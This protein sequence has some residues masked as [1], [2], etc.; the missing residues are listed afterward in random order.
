MLL[1]NLR[2]IIRTTIIRQNLSIIY[3]LIVLF[4]LFFIILISNVIYCY[5]YK[6]IAQSSIYI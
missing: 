5:G 6:G 3:L 1:K 2:I 4:V